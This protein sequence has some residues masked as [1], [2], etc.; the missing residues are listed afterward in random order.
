M[1]SVSFRIWTRVAVSIFFDDNHYTTVAPPQKIYV[2]YIDCILE[3]VQ[4]SPNECP[5]YDA[6]QSDREAPNECPV[7]TLNNLIERFPKNILDM[8]LNEC[9]G[10][11]TN[12]PDREAPNDC[13]VYDT[14][15]SDREALENVE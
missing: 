14:N 7:M 3:E 4:D 5:T 15:Q 2:E 11:D 6:K 10:Y 13:P 12:Q 1:Q 8:R 9:P